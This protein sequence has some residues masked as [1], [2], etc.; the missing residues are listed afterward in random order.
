MATERTTPPA[1]LA[2]RYLKVY[3]AIVADVLDQLDLRT[4]ALPSELVPLKPGMKL[5]GPAYVCEGKPKPDADFEASM[6]KMLNWLES[7]PAHAVAVYKSHG[8]GSAHFGDMSASSLLARGCTGALIDGGCRDVEMVLE[9]GIPVFTRYR[10]PQDCVP[11]W[12]LVEWGHAVQI[13][14]VTVTSGDY[15]FADADGVVVIPAA[16]TEEVL[17]RAEKMVATEREIREKVVGGETPTTLYD[18]Y[19]IF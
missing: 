6:R 4:Q 19:G 5:A 14:D 10:N 12:D 18:E 15:V 16:L 8:D 2:Q 11:R 13:G 3:T 1:E 7:V 17:E 9:S